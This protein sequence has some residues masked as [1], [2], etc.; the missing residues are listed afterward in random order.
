MYCDWL[1][2]T[3]TFSGVTRHTSFGMFSACIDDIKG[4]SETTVRP[5][6]DAVAAAAR[7]R[8]AYLIVKQMV[9]AVTRVSVGNQ[10]G[11]SRS[12]ECA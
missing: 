7:K 9:D 4:T 11:E 6:G 3:L 2:A 8:A 12:M 1:A 10:Y 5:I